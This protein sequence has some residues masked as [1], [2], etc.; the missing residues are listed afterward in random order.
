MLN[1]KVLGSAIG[2]G[3]A[4]I[5]DGNPKKQLAWRFRFPQLGGLGFGSDESIFLEISLSLW[6]IADFLI[7]IRLSVRRDLGF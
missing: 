5:I 3:V 4:H 1:G 2:R 7:T 6:A